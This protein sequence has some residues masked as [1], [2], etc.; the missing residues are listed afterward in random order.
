M[1]NGAICLS[2]VARQLG[3]SDIEALLDRTARE[4]P[5]PSG[6]V[7]LPYLSGERTPHNDPDARGAFVGLSQETTPASLVR[8]VLEGVAYSCV[9]ARDCLSGAGTELSALSVIGGGSR[10]AFWMTIVASA[11]NLPLTRYHGGET[12]TAFGAARLARI[13]LTSEPVQDVCSKPPVRDIINPDAA[14]ATR[15]ADRMAHFR[16]LYVRLKGAFL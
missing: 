16:D 15:Y 10:S 9:E 3:A 13:A 7:F 5:D 6:L 1:L 4:A 14:L 2:W 11:L 8:A 12:G